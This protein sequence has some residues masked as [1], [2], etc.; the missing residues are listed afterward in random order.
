MFM[1]IGTVVQ[2]RITLVVESLLMDQNS[3]YL[4]SQQITTG[5]FVTFLVPVF[6]LSYIK[7]KLNNYPETY[8]DDDIA[9]DVANLQLPLACIQSFLMLVIIF[10]NGSKPP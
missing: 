2:Q 8:D 5:M 1:L 4:D 7:S 9:G 3:D 10:T 6:Q